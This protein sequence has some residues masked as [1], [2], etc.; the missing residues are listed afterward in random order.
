MKGQDKLSGAHASASIGRRIAW[1]LA[2]A[3][4]LCAGL[5]SPAS[6]VVL[7]APPG[8]AS[9][10][11]LPLGSW[12]GVTY[13]DR[14]GVC[15]GFVGATGA[16][17]T[18]SAIS[19]TGA[20]WSSGGSTAFGGT[21]TWT[22]IGTD[23]TSTVVL[24]GSTTTHWTA[25][26]TNCG[27]TW[28]QGTTGADMYFSWK[29]VAFDGTRFVAIADGAG[30][31]AT[32]YSADGINWAAGVS[33][34]VVDD[35]PAPGGS[36]SW[37]RIAANNA[38]TFVVMSAQG[39]F[40]YSTNHG[41][42]WSSPASL[43]S[44]P[45][46][47]SVGALAFGGGTFVV[48]AGGSIGTLSWTS[49]DGITW[50][51]GG[52]MP[53]AAPWTA[54]A[55]GDSTFVAVSAVN[56]GT[57]YSASS[58][59][60]G[61]TWVAGLNMPGTAEWRHLAFG[62][63]TVAALATNYTTSAAY[64]VAPAAATVTSISPSGGAPAGGTSVTITG[65][66]FESGATVTIGGAAATSVSFV[67]STT[68]TAVTPSGAVGSADVA[69]T[70]PAA[71]AGTL[72]GG[73][74]YAAA[75][76]VT[77]I[78]PASGSESG[79]T[80]VTITGTG[81]VSGATVTIGGAAATGVVF[82]SATAL[83]AT[84]PAG[85]V[86]AKNVVVTNPD[87]QTGTL[88]NGYTYASGGGG[89]G[90]SG[91]ATPAASPTPSAPVIITP[92]LTRPDSLGPNEASDMT[93]VPPGKSRATQDGIPIQT[94]LSTDPSFD[95]ATIMGDGWD[96]SLVSNT[97]PDKGARIGPAG[98]MLIP[99]GGRIVVS[100]RGYAPG[101]RVQVYA[102]NPALLLGT[103]AVDADGRF[104]GS[105]DAPPTITPG[106]VVLQVNGYAVN[107]SVR[108]ASFG[109]SIVKPVDAARFK[110]E[111][112]T[113]LFAAGS[114][115]LSGAAKQ[116]LARVAQGVPA[117]ARSVV[118]V[119]T[120]YVQGTRDTANDHAL[121]TARAA[122]VAQALKAGGLKARYYVTGRGVAV[123]RGPLARKVVVRISY[124]SGP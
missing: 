1:A 82:G 26:S 12:Q 89:G 106:D 85:T 122:N 83:T 45:A 63:H 105:L 7:P 15:S 93:T 95:R 32:M 18:L 52:L 97:P 16:T 33:G 124:R 53:Q 74:T 35:L 31:T 121:S 49:T 50:A 4:F 22:T 39:K 34:G 61:A 8:W 90:G 38:G 110:K 113:I 14:F 40:T 116:D 30:A 101:T 13:V 73:Y 118:V 42:T 87:T 3:A 81:F 108:S 98:V 24:L 6:A 79:G 19:T 28:Q 120:G 70:N 11:G 51:S 9:A 78:S 25:Y 80:S 109:V 46:S 115:R 43:P 100:G 5:S 119:S 117:G 55:F 44:L 67:N 99:Q 36:D 54:L 102:M 58:T 123:E 96:V 62:A 57:S 77:G 68:L 48:T 17:E 92:I 75:P 104:S 71:T 94:T 59:D 29:S 64:T 56:A 76:T 114:S 69:V 84:T 88:S 23:A 107:L 37:Y 91:D 2:I 60:G 27:A 21:S 66:G 41:N 111:E 47:P 86:G 10:S 72:T 112:A 103:I 65:T 20:T